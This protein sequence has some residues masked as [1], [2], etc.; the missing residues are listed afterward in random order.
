MQR[1]CIWYV[2]NVQEEDADDYVIA[3][4]ETHTIKEFINLA[5]AECG[6]E[7]EWIGEGID[8]EAVTKIEQI[9]KLIQVISDQLR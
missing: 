6:I 4:G 5:L 8:E 1:L 9:V 7:F 2:A 3:T